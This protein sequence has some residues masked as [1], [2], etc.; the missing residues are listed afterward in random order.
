MPKPMLIPFIPPVT[1]GGKS[2]PVVANLFDGSGNF[3][4]RHGSFKRLR[5]DGSAGAASDSYYDLS[6]DVSV[7]A[8]PTA[9][10]LDV[11]RIRDL[12]V[13]ANQMAGAVRS[14]L[15][16][17][18]VSDEMK[19]LA[20]FN[21]VMLDLVS[22]VVEEGIL[23][24]SSSTAATASFSSVAGAAPPAPS[25]P[26]RPRV[27][28]GTAELKAAL[29]TADKSAV[30][31]DADLGPSPVANQATL[32][33]AL[34]AGLKAATLKVAADAGMD[35]NEAIRVVNDAL[36]CADNVDFKG[37]TSSKHIDKRDPNNP[38]VMPFCSMPVKLDFPDRNTRI[39][40]ERT[41]RKHCNLRATISLPTIIRQYQALY[42]NA[43]KERYPG[44]A[45]MVR[46]DVASLSLVA[47]VKEEGG[48]AWT[49]CPG[50]HPIPRGIMLPDYTLPNRVDLPAAGDAEL[51]DGDD[52]M[53]VAA[54]IGAE[55]QP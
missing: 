55:S 33:G 1:I 18:G 6:R 7:A 19:E 31:F 52:A 49:R 38:I 45:V 21:M 48:G 47:L 36:S 23:P 8:V 20:R 53:L 12:L 25:V 9:P 41:I 40:F 51:G 27:E 16:A 43:V 10:K 35:A 54:S 28:P 30:V 34:A 22:A 4:Q 11:G 15:S 42:L 46:P 39:H 29:A 2:T 37:Q 50:G 17:D 44:R 5:T 32:N 13:K 14:R 26:S 3:C 24:L